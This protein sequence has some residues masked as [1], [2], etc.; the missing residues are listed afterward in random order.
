MEHLIIFTTHTS[1]SERQ[2]LDSLFFVLSFFAF[3]QTPS[4]S[5]LGKS[6]NRK[7]S[8]ECKSKA[9]LLLLLVKSLE[10]S[11]ANKR[12]ARRDARFSLPAH[13]Q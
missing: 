4:L 1:R 8:V 2:V 7:G 5:I 6:M 13:V 3:F 9:A 11:V 12:T 10:G